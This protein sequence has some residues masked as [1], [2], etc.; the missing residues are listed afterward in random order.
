MEPVSQQC[1]HSPIWR[2]LT[3]YL[4]QSNTA[5]TDLDMSG[6]EAG[7]ESTLARLASSLWMAE[8]SEVG[9]A[10][11]PGTEWTPSD[12]TQIENNNIWHQY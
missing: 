10:A 9:L 5:N 6:E 12:K 11:E 2:K 8:A 3:D 4:K 7:D 1:T